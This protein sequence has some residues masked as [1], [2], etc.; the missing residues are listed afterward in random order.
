LS[1]TG[2]GSLGRRSTFKDREAHQTVWVRNNRY[3]LH[4]Y[5]RDL[6]ASKYSLIPRVLTNLFSNIRERIFGRKIQ[7]TKF[8]I[9][10]RIRRI[11]IRIEFSFIFKIRTL[12]NEHSNTPAHAYLRLTYDL[13]TNFRSND[14][15]KVL[16]RLGSEARA[17]PSDAHWPSAAEK[18]IDLIRGELDAVMYDFP[19]L[20]TTSAFKVAV[21][22]V[23][24][25][26]TDS[27]NATRT[28]VHNDCS[29]Q[30]LG[31]TAALT[32]E[33]LI[34]YRRA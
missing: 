30:P 20:S 17:V 21:L 32:A 16:E 15:R 22:R 7:N 33:C 13:G 6:L 19:E 11:R 12:R 10:I 27:K 9:R 23:S 8:G 14:F 25:R 29:I 28:S 1:C 26:V 5:V 3:F 31:L 24:S 4:L 18:S 34:G 2:A